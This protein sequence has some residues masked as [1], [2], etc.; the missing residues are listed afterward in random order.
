LH[1]QLPGDNPYG[2]TQANINWICA[3]CHTGP[4]PQF[5]GGMS[6]WNSAESSDAVRGGCYARLRGTDCHDPHLAT[7]LVWPHA[8]DHDDGLCLRSQEAYRDAT[9]RRSHTHHAPGSAG[10]RCMN[11]HMPRVNE[12]LDTVVRTHTIFSPT[13]AVVLEKNGPNACNLCHLDRS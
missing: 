8:A 6:T 9:A 1:A 11:C 7:G 4:R 3:R 5:P 2:R 13:K 10:D 12:G